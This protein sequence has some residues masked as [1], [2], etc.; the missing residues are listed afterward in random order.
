MSDSLL[1]G[2][3][4]Q[5]GGD[6]IGQL[7]GLVGADQQATGKAVAAALPM[8]L[9]SLTGAAKQPSG[10]EALFGALS[11][12]HDG[13]ILDMLGPLLGGGYASRAMGSDGARILG[14]VFGN[15]QPAV[16]QTVAQNAGISSGLVSK[17]LPYL[18]P[19][20]MGYLSKRLMGGGGGDAGLLGSMLGQEQEQIRQQDSGLGGLFDLLGGGNDDN[21][22]GGGLMDAA[23]D[24]LGS[25][26]GKA[27]LGQILK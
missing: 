6:T 15:K 5:F 21:D 11:N 4:Q 20:V 27:I 3:A 1:T 19:I 14:H 8:L 9:G 25:S 2:L 16:E 17:L 26:V 24:L 12:D 10:A 22:D 7:A 23:G 18:A 13:S